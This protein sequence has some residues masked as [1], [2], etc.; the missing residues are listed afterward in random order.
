M[1]FMYTV[2]NYSALIKEETLSFASRTIFLVAWP[3]GLVPFLPFHLFRVLEAGGRITGRQTPYSKTV[4]LERGSGCGGLD[5][6]KKLIRYL[7]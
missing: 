5:L 4:F 6:S 1:W 3:V 7:G 2:E